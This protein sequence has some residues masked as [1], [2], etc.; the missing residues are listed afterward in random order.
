MSTSPYIFDA[1]LENFQQGVLDNSHKVPVLVDFWADW[2]Q[3]CKML[4]PILDKLVNEFDGKIVLAK[5][6]SDQQAE[7]STRYQVRGIPN[8]K[9]FRNGQMVD[10][11]TGVQTE[12]TIR[13]MIERHLPNE[14][15]DL[16]NQALAMI[17]E[18]NM[19]GG[20]ELLLEVEQKDPR[21]VLV[22]IDLAH[23][24]AQKGDYEAARDRLLTLGSD[25][26]EK[27]E[28][29]S[30]LAKMEFAAAAREAHD[31]QTLLEQIE[32]D[33]K[34]SAARFQLASLCVMEGDYETALEQ[35]L[36][37]LM[38]DRKYND[39]A[40]RRAML[41]I[42]AMLGGDH[43]LTATYRRKMFNAMH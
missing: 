6:N 23:L 38:R 32:A 26:R 30:L 20:H 9:L 25:S 2:C 43:P 34:N 7:L 11:F 14:L 17:R 13:A 10:E 40:G 27:P 28:V 15:D 3:P 42:F 39:D 31:K 37:I 22:Q 16:R 36:Q 18:G 21:H 19:A 8:V 12:D 29:V 24:E 4:M 1:T 35:L 5:V 33:A 41:S